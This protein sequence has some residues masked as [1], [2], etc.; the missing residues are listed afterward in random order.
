VLNEVTSKV[1]SFPASVSIIL[2]TPV[3]PPPAL[4]PKEA[5]ELV[6]RLA[7][8]RGEEQWKAIYDLPTNQQHY[9]QQALAVK[10]AGSSV[11]PPKFAP[12]A[13]P[14]FSLLLNIFPES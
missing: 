13:A 5:V 11:I 12:P 4:E 9:V 10:E 2:T 3:V 14:S 6:D 8:L 1:K 7:L